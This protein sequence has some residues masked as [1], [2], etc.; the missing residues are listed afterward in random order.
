MSAIPDPRIDERES[1]YYRRRLSGRELVPAV[2]IGIGV[3]L[4]AFYVARLLAQRGPLMAVS[5][6]PRL[7]S[8]IDG[9]AG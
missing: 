4:V 7:R 6:A 8:R 5:R 2:A 1:Y 3:G 9:E